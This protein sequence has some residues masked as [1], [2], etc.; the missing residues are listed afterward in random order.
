MGSDSFRS[1][2]LLIVLLFVGIQIFYAQRLP[3]VMDEFDGAYDTYRLRRDIPYRDFPPYKTVLGYYL[4]YPATLFASTVW[5]RILALKLE[6]IIVNAVMLT[7]AAFYCSRFLP[8]SGVALS[9]AMLSASTVML[10]R[11][12]EIRVDMLTAWAGLWS[13]LFLLQRRFALAGLLCALS[14][15]I[16]QKAALYVLASNMTLLLAVLLDR[17]RRSAFRGLLSFNLSAGAALI[18]YLGFWSA[19][20]DPAT[21]L[22]ATFQWASS[23]ALNVAYGIQW[24]FWSQVLVRNFFFIALAVAAI[25]ALLTRRADS[26]L[27]ATATYSLVLLLLCAIYTQPWP[28]FF[29]IL[30]PTLFVLNAAFLGSIE[31]AAYSRVL[32][33]IC[34]ILGVVYPLHR[35]FVYPQR[36]SDYQ[37]YN[38]TLASALLDVDETYFAGN[39]IVHDREQTL[40]P[41][42]SRFDAIVLRVLAGQDSSRHR[43]MIRE[44]QRKP[45]KL[46][47]GTYRIYGLPPLLRDWMQSNYV[48]LSG[49][50]YLY[51]PLLPA[52]SGTLRLPFAGRYRAEV[53]S[54]KPV[55]ID[56]R[57]VPHGTFI[58]LTAGPHVI[59]SPSALRLRLLP[60]GIEA[61]LDRDY[62]EE[63]HFYQQV[64]D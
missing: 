23:T 37:R 49:S 50:I 64:Y 19:I 27:R 6:I 38:V 59:S 9:L 53:Q 28:Y 42:S 5:G 40:G 1:T 36:S 10:E 52:G 8:R 33:A 47:I 15:G 55:T 58:E 26:V 2:V 56:G 61:R 39:D 44:L 31:R 29:V 12:G 3:L 14:F 35:V 17:D 34:V 13:F 22:R 20:G 24:R 51:A 41:L 18:A 30:F 16:S 11:A 25:V 63:R 7:A 43:Q 21:V 48:R 46:V 54:G 60:A 4:Q 45:P 57:H 62:A 32:M